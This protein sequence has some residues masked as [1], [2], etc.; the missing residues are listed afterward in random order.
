MH[1]CDVCGRRFATERGLNVHLSKKHGMT[2][3]THVGKTCTV[4]GAS[5]TCKRALAERSQYCSPEC[6]HEGQRNGERRMCPV[7]GE[8]FYTQPSQDFSY[9]SQ[10]CAGIAKAGANNPNWQGGLIE[11]QCTHCHKRMMRHPS[12]VSDEHG[13]FCDAV[14]HGAWI[15][16]HLNG[17]NNPNWREGKTV[18]ECEICG[19]EVLR[20]PTQI[21]Q[22]IFCSTGCRNIW[23][24]RT[25]RGENHP[26]WKGGPS[27]Q[28]DRWYYEEGGEWTKHVYARAHFHCE[29]C[30]ERGTLHAHHH[31]GWTNFPHW[32]S[33]LWNGI[34][35]CE[36]CHRRFHSRIGYAERIARAYQAFERHQREALELVPLA[37]PAVA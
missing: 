8:E 27:D 37:L 35:L 36:D 11:V 26:N 4:C 23:Q 13:S 9:C 14:C 34:C 20:Y 7:C 21:H 6:K 31:W 10:A 3:P 1:R 32:R 25:K 17:D 29:R 28:R 33:E 2:N 15:S 19:A 12:H 18:Y 24:S 30:G 22:H 5:Y 16:E